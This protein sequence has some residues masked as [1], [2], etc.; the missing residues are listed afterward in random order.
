[1]FLGCRRGMLSTC[2]FFLASSTA[3]SEIVIVLKNKFIED[4]KDRVTIQADFTVDKAHARPNPPSKDGDLHVAGREP[5]IEPP[6]VAEIMNARS[7]KE[8]VQAI[9]DAEGA[10]EPI[11]I[12]GAWRIW[13]EHGGD[14]KQVQGAKLK[15]FKTTNPD[16][17]FEIHPITQIEDRSLLKSLK[18]IK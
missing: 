8:A 14:S 5:Q 16:H 15:P 6:T 11:K 12:A 7:E 18:P 13:C 4:Y 3:R 2:L 10:E 17:V 1:N 9:H